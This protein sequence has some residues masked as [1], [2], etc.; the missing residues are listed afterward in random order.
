MVVAKDKK[1]ILPKSRPRNRT[2]AI[3]LVALCVM[4][5]SSSWDTPLRTC[6]RH[7]PLQ[8]LCR[9]GAQALGSDGSS[10]GSLYVCSSCPWIQEHWQ[11]R[12][13]KLLTRRVDAAGTKSLSCELASGLKHTSND[14]CAPR[15]T[16]HGK[17]RSSQ[18]THTLPYRHIFRT[19][20]IFYL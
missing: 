18:S 9:S 19:A 6:L 11:G 3:H 1:T 16:A 20:A 5:I 10:L 13:Y 12:P 2:I 17:P 4:G 14:L 15:P 8:I 7:Q